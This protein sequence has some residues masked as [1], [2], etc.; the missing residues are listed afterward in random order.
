MNNL[1]MMF[2]CARKA[3]E[4]KGSGGLKVGNQKMKYAEAMELLYAVEMYFSHKGAFTFGICDTC[5]Y[6]DTKYMLS[7]HKYMGKCGSKIVNKFDS[8][9]RHSIRGGGYGL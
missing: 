8:C 9:E 3:L 1:K 5:E 7:G 6:F 4:D 2:H